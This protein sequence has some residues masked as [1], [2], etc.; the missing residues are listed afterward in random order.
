MR[1]TNWHKHFKV[2]FKDMASNKKTNTISKKPFAPRLKPI[3]RYK[4]PVLTILVLLFA[5]A[6]AVFIFNTFA[7]RIPVYRTNAD[8]WRPRIAGCESG[9]G[10]NSKPNYKAFN[11]IAHYGAYQF[12]IGT[13]RS[14][15]DPGTAALYPKASD[16]PPAVQD[17]AFNSTFKKRGTQPWNASYYC[18]IQGALPPAQEE[19][20]PKGPPPGSYNTTIS[21]RIATDDDKPI[22]DVVLQTCAESLSV[23]T[24]ELGRFSFNLPAKRDFC[25]RVVSGVPSEFKLS[26]TSNNVEHINAVSYEYQK[27]GYSCYRN[28]MCLLS[29]Q[30]EWDRRADNG[31]NFFYTKP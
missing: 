12:D 27:A 10:P 31:Y 26:R 4:R 20:V 29:P 11:G 3:A 16:A 19:V 1:L 18:W 30:Y 7:G 21:G 14:N 17:Q 22:K 2:E 23:K 24:N 8:Y 25:L 13:W 5:V 28:L 6:G 15:V 9:S